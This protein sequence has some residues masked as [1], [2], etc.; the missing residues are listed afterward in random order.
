MKYF[1]LIPSYIGLFIHSF[2]KHLLRACHLLGA[3]LD[4]GI[5]SWKS[6]APVLILVNLQPECL[7]GRL[8][9]QLEAGSLYALTCLQS[10]SFLIYHR[11]SSKSF[12]FSSC[13]PHSSFFTPSTW[14]C[15]LFKVKNGLFIGNLLTILSLYQVYLSMVIMT[16]FPSCIRES[17]FRPKTSTWTLDP[18]IWLIHSFWLSSVYHY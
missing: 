12:P 18:R 15:L 1:Y 3:L 4:M 9:F 10:A 13:L 2:I 14:S 5:Q 8:S 11:C 17:D 7:F 16:S 6:P